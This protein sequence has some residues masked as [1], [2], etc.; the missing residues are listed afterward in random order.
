MQI[1]KNKVGLCTCWVRIRFVGHCAVVFLIVIPR[2]ERVMHSP[3]QGVRIGCHSQFT[4]GVRGHT[5]YKFFGVF[6]VDP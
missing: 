2:Q 3:D 1:G 4:D 5:P 6:S